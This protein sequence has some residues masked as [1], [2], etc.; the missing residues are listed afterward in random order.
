M[1]L[2][3]FDD[4]AS[5]SW[6]AGLGLVTSPFMARAAVPAAAQVDDEVSVVF[7]LYRFLIAHAARARSRPYSTRY[8]LGA[9]IYTTG[10]QIGMLS[11][12][13]ML[14]TI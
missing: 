8:H 14:P 4:M 2:R 3:D 9:S 12:V 11:R 1:S 5:D 6:R 10:I 7:R 13:N